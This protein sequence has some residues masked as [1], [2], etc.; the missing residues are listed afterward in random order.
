[1]VERRQSNRKRIMRALT[2]NELSAVDRPAQAHAVKTL[3][4]RDDAAGI[5]VQG[6]EG[7]HVAWVSEDLTEKKYKTVA[8]L[9]AAVRGNLPTA[10]QQ[11][12]LAV[13][14]SVKDGGAAD[15]SAFQQAWGAL[16]NAGWS[17]NKEGKWI[18]KAAPTKSEDGQNFGAGDYAYVPDPSKPS[19]WKLRLT[20][21]PGGA[22][23]AAMVGAA[24][25]AFSPGGH[26]GQKVSLPSADVAGAKSKVR[27]AWRK[28]NP[29]KDASAMPDGI[30]KD[31]GDSMPTPE[32]VSQEIQAVDFDTVLA[33]DEAREAAQEVGQELR[34]KWCALQRA[35]ATIIADESV[36]A[37]DKITAMQASLQQ[38]ID[39]LAEQ[40]QTI[41]DEMT[42][43]LNAVPA[44]AELLKQTG[45]D[46][47]DDA[48]T[49]AEKKQ[50]AEL[51]K[52]VTD[53]TAKLEAATA[54]EP[55]KKAADLQGELDAAKAQ[56]AELTKKIEDGDAEKAEAV[57]KA[58][59]SDA[60]KAH[61]ATLTGKAKMDFMQASSADR[62]KMMSKAAETDEVIKVGDREIRK[63]V[64]GDDQ[65]A[66]IKSQQDEI[67]KQ[68]DRIAKAEEARETAELT[69]RAGE[70]P[71][72]K[73]AVE[74]P[75][76]VEVLR[77]IDKMSEKPRET[78][79]KMLEV[80]AKAVDA[81][82]VKI[83]HNHEQAQKSAD[84]FNKRVD[85]VAARDKISKAAA[86]SKARVE[87]KDEYEAY[88]AAS[89]AQA[90]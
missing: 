68:A 23:D 36:S 31:Y 77:A 11:Q 46:E 2:I 82:F 33:E 62:A 38:Y 86:M 49:D 28:A 24:A 25:A 47:G 55:A 12:F 66:V 51:T 61:M 13:F 14:N 22:P 9:P 41:A 88:Q 65:F 80:G 18:K 78:L 48:M 50:L 8:D 74:V 76:K 34:E 84:D 27:A 87:F 39:S 52:Q 17:K 71:I 70:G 72:S 5:R 4:K 20:A 43:S 69:K 90:N 3:M 21:S 58:G 75:D 42:K 1:M 29:D 79:L 81:A 19:T 53:L 40:S 83:G 45:N 44:I 26:R 37:P 57:A 73:Y 56:V 35:F 15:Q 7:K 64:V 67:A 10:A 32:V 6:M 60:E 85:E 16:R 63:S 54:K 89:G 59:M 30:K